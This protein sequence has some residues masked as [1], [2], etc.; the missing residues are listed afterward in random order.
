MTI[1]QTVRRV[2]AYDIDENDFLQYLKK[3]NPDYEDIQK[4][5][6]LREL[7]DMIS[8]LDEFGGELDTYLFNKEMH[9]ET[10]Y[11]TDSPSSYYEDWEDAYNEMEFGIH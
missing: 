7:I 10:E 11:I 3:T 2:Y 4:A 6:S 1:Y 5:N 8:C 9:E